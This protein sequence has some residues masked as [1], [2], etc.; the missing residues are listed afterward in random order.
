[1]QLLEH[2][3]D[4]RNKSIP[5]QREIRGFIY[6]SLGKLPDAIFAFLLIQRFLRPLLDEGRILDLLPPIW[7]LPDSI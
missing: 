3:V 7:F 5:R 1:M 4:L 6:H 2:I